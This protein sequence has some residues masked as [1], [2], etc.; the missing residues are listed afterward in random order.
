MVDS[1]MEYSKRRRRLD[2]K[3]PNPEQIQWYTLIPRILAVYNNKNIHSST[4]KTPN[5]GRKVSNEVDA[6]AS[7]EMR[8][9]HGRKYPTL[10]VGDTVKILRKK[11]Q[12]GDKEFMSDFK[13]GEHKVTSISSNFD[14]KFY[15]LSD[16][17]EYIRID[18]VK[19]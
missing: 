10:E 16:G 8:A 1:Q 13:S 14:Q 12:V 5:D 3:T 7:M 9:T 18:I 11:K 4:G 19:M 15:R 17:R 2:T 6:K